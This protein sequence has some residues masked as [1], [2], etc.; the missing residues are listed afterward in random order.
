MKKTLLT[1]VLLVSALLMAKAGNYKNFK[2]VA[3]VMVQTVNQVG[4]QQKWEELWKDYSKN[5]KLDKVYLETF[6]D[7]NFVEDKAMKE[8]IK[9]FKSKGIE[10][11]GGITY[12]YSG[13]DRQ[14]WET[15]CYS[16]PE[17]LKIIKQV[18]E[19][20]AGYFDEIVLDD[21]YFTNCKCD[22]CIA[23]K[24][25]RSWAEFRMEL[26]DNAAKNYI[27]GP[28][29]QVNPKCKVIV[30]YPNWYDHFQGLGFDL[31]HGPY[32]FDGVYTGT[33]TRDPTSE[34]HLQTYESF[35]IIRYFESLRPGHNF[36]GWVDTGGANY[37]DRFAEQLWLTLL[38][39]AP[40]S[41]LF[42]FGSMGN[43]FRDV[44]RSWEDMNPTLNMKELKAESLKRGIEKPTWGR[45]AEY[46]YDKI[47]PILSHL[48]T[49]KGIKAYKP[50][51]ALGEEFLHNY[52]GMIG[53][54]V[55]LTSV[56]PEFGE[57]C[58]LV[59]LTEAAAK[60]KNI[61]DKMKKFMQKGGEVVVTS[62]FYR[63]MQDKGVRNIF[64]MTYTDRK[65][66]VKTII[67]SSN[68]GPQR[69]KE[70]DVSIKIPVMTYYTNDSWEDITTLEYENGW[71]LLQYSVYSKGD[72]FVWVIPENFSH[73]YALPDNA[74][75]RLRA[76][77]SA[78]MDVQ[79][80]GPSQVSLFTYDN[81]TF[82]VHSFH[83]TPVE[84]NLVVRSSKGVTD[85]ESKEVISGTQAQSQKIYGRQRYE[86]STC[87]VTIP[88][89]SFRAFKINK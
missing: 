87:K 13:G 79:I 54:P 45:I 11:S 16:N 88:P 43:A 83:D 62:G 67:V 28:A 46:A 23:A 59:I 18:A 44:Q 72:I 60:D 2:S 66:D 52:M 3:Y 32:T 73:L 77:V 5:L 63:E 26:L 61:I 58:K 10:V 71:P 75:N 64:D 1:I 65:A 53:I 81:D 51:H 82:V 37:P 22:D 89:H 30:K 42:N 7:M 47:D 24:G 80:E 48:G 68:Y 50:F 39:K 55:E 86:A 33:E 9:F 34:Q 38:A 56:F 8:A 69:S 20:T 57:D 4:T 15:F 14:R 85:I 70:A 84:I 40:E 74:L 35:G 17:H 76:V 12:N 29:K 78:D 27:I 6:R 41:T 19:T 49:P 31:E 36:G 21:Y 25:E